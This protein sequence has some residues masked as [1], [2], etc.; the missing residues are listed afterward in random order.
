VDKA[1]GAL[2]EAVRAHVGQEPAIVV[3][4][5]HGESLFEEGFL[6]HGYVLNDVQ[7]R[8]PLVAA[9]LALDL[10]E[11]VGQADLRGA[12]VAAL[13]RPSAEAR[14]TFRACA[15]HMVFQYLGTLN[16]P[17][18]IAFTGPSGRL[19][20]DVREQVVQFDGG[21]WTAVVALDD[22]RRSQ[23]LALVRHWERLRLAG[24]PTEE[25]AS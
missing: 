24:V 16:R 11:P 21:A 2:R 20:Y 1:I 8:I 6:G 23:W 7:T 13:A 17:R 14:P 19:V 18:Q 3:L 10:C 4:A 15:D 25:G 12:I 22:T 5:D 9:G